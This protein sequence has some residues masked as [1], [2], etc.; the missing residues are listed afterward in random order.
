MT[1][2][3]W[4]ILVWNTISTGYYCHAWKIRNGDNIPRTVESLKPSDGQLVMMIAAQTG[5]A[6]RETVEAWRADFIRNGKT[7]EGV[8]TS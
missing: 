3:T 6:A 8:W 5:K 4:F 1:G 2:Y 7:H